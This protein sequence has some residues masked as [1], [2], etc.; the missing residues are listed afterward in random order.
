MQVRTILTEGPQF[1]NFRRD[2]KQNHIR[3]RKGGP[4]ITL[5]YILWSNHCPILL[6]KVKLSSTV[7]MTVLPNV[8]R[9]EPVSF[10]VYSTVYRNCN[11]KSWTFFYK[12]TQFMLP[13]YEKLK[14]LVETFNPYNQI[15]IFTEQLCISNMDCYI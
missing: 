15:L 12:H 5:L 10:V 4:Y 11:A 6:L 14:Y 2:L 3:I 13:S 7:N 1:K 9:F 8:H